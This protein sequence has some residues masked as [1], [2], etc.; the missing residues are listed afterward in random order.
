[1]LWKHECS[2]YAS[3]SRIGY[4]PN[5]PSA[6]RPGSRP[7]S[8]A[9][10]LRPM[11]TGRHQPHHEQQRACSS[12]NIDRIDTGGKGVTG[13]TRPRSA[14][15]RLEVSSQATQASTASTRRDIDGS[16]TCG[17]GSNYDQGTD[18]HD[19]RGGSGRRRAASARRPPSS[20]RD[21]G[22]SCSEDGGD[23]IYDDIYEDL[24][25]DDG[26]LDNRISIMESRF[27]TSGRERTRP[28]SARLDDGGASFRGIKNAE[29]DKGKTPEHLR[30]AHSARP[31]RA[32]PEP[33]SAT[34]RRLHSAAPD[35]TAEGGTTA[36]GVDGSPSFVG[37]DG[38]R[39]PRVIKSRPISAPPGGS[40]SSAHRADPVAALRERRVRLELSS[41]GDWHRSATTGIV[42]REEHHTGIDARQQEQ[43]EQRRPSRLPV[44]D[45]RTF[46]RWRKIFCLCLV[47]SCDRTSC[48]YASM[49]FPCKLKS[50]AR[51]SSRGPK[52]HGNGGT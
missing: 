20:L 28:G 19:K 41:A 9:T 42:L 37:V 6:S 4:H 21:R 3:S 34:S 31:P 39:A 50:S 22:G 44:R 8:A 43:Q 26:E 27:S 36:R 13:A 12:E 29:T 38:T 2:R 24:E 7:S 18:Q 40:L 30:S 5:H 33:R 48:V 17:Q 51:R 1:M 52:A 45:V 32:P 14:V 46:A 25:E 10:V 23:G 49:Q 35:R 15:P 47:A 16:S 11:S